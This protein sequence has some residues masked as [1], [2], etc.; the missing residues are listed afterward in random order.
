MWHQIF[1]PFNCMD[2]YLEYLFIYLRYVCSYS[3]GKT[4]RERERERERCMKQMYLYRER[5]RETL[6][7]L[8]NP[9]GLEDSVQNSHSVLDLDVTMRTSWPRARSEWV[10][11]W[12]SNVYSS[13]TYCIGKWQMVCN[14]VHNVGITH[15]KQ[16]CFAYF[17]LSQQWK[18]NLNCQQTFLSLSPF[19]IYKSLSRHLISFLC[20]ALLR[21]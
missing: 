11:R 13:H 6:K 20:F 18:W 1:F 15:M 10:T 9:C 16:N 3:W 21:Q 5:E 7:Y 17:L 2:L 12:M 8:G 4:Q 14:G 19:S